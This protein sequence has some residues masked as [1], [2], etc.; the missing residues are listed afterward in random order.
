MRTLVK[1]GFMASD[2]VPPALLAELH[3]LWP[4][5]L[6][7]SGF[8]FEEDE[9]DPITREVL[10]TLRRHGY[11][12]WTDYTRALLADCEYSMKRVRKYDVSDFEQA[13]FLEPNPD[14]GTLD[15]L[16]DD[17]NRLYLHYR[18]L[19]RRRKIVC[20]DSFNLVC[21]NATRQLLES[22]QLE[23]LAFREAV[24][25][26]QHS[27]SRGGK[28]V[29]D[30][31]PWWEIIAETTLPPV[32]EHVRKLG[33]NGAIWPRDCPTPVS[34]SDGDFFGWE[35][36]YCRS[37]INSLPPFDIAMTYEYLSGGQVSRIRVVSNRFWRA[38]REH[39]LY[40]CWTPVRIEDC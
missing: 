20:A 18:Q 25:A 30:H 11:S 22:Q 14:D 37:E 6:T 16:R 15:A 13:E 31:E 24:V 19:P 34:L 36:H 27:P 17:H 35:L 39:E 9:T 5:S 23:G 1:L 40:S 28:P 33:F 38:C 10:E 29:T 12:R 3:G 26:T 4:H 2:E 8:R 21:S 7:P 32:S